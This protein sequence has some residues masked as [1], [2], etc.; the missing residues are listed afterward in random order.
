MFRTPRL[1]AILLS[2]YSCWSFSEPLKIQLT[3]QGQLQSAPGAVIWLRATKPNG[4]VSEEGG[5][6]TEQAASTAHIIEQRDRQFSPYISVTQVGRDIQF[7]NRDNTAH[8]V[9]SFSEPLSFELPLFKKRTPAPIR[10][11]KPGLIA[12]GCNIHDWMIAYLVVVDSPFYGQLH[13]QVVE[14]A[15][16]PHGE[17]QAL[18]WHPDI[19]SA[20]VL[21]TQLNYQ[22]Q[23]QFQWPIPQKI[24]AKAQIK[25]PVERLDEDDDY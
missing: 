18:L 12:L 6:L 5:K 8:H 21:K 2:I 4:A 17:Y 15:G 25:A 11:E 3:H 22:G 9:Y 1:A 20:Q 7:P 16:L 13:N 14:F 19:N 23:K 10:V 24:N